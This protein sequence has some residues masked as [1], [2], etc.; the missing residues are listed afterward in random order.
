MKSTKCKTRQ[1]LFDKCERNPILWHEIQPKEVCNHF[2]AS[3]A[4]LIYNKKSLH[5]SQ[6]NV[7]PADLASNIIVTNW[8]SLQQLTN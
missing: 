6:M 7:N 8:D 1:E 5:V 4:I 3:S 2:N